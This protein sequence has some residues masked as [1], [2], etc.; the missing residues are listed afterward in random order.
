MSPAKPG[1]VPSPG[2]TSSTSVS[3]HAREDSEERPGRG[4]FRFREYTLTPDRRRDAEPVMYQMR[5]ASCDASGPDSADATDGT[6][7]ALQ[8]LKR[9]PTHLDFREH[10]TRSYRAK[11]GAWR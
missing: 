4:V 2:T 8:H 11:A 7:W 6:M 1:L 9:N 10:V 5:C 3:E